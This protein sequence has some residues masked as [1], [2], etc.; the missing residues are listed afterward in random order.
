[1]K[2]LIIIFSFIM[3][4][5]IYAMNLLDYET[6]EKKLLSRIGSFFLIRLWEVCRKVVLV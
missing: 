5:K 1:M 3:S 4:E 2:Y 6:E